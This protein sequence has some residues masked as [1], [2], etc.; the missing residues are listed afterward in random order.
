MT[1]DGV[2]DAPSIKTA[3]I[4]TAFSIIKGDEVKVN[5]D[6]TKKDMTESF[7]EPTLKFTAYAIQSANLPAEN[8]TVEKAWALAH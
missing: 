4:G 6:V 3:D 2:N 7:T 5:S 1:G 8:N